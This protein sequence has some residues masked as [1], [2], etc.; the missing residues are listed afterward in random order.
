MIAKPT[1]KTI[2]LAILLI[3][4]VALLGWLFNGDHSGANPS[5]KAAKD[6]TATT[7]RARLRKSTP[8]GKRNNLRPANIDVRKR[9][10]A[11]YVQYPELAIPIKDPEKS[12]VG[13]YEDLFP[14]DDNTALH[15]ELETFETMLKKEA[16]WTEN[17]KQSAID[18]LAQEQ[19]RLNVMM[20]HSDA[21][22]HFQNSNGLS[23]FQT[24]LMPSFRLLA[25]S[26][27]LNAKLG[28]TADAIKIYQSSNQLFNLAQKG[29]LLDMTIS[30]IWRQQI[31]EY[32]TAP[33]LA[34]EAVLTGILDSPF[35]K[36]FTYS[37]TLKGEFASCTALIYGGFEL[38][39]NG[40]IILNF[41]AGAPLVSLHE[42]ENTIALYYMD[43][44]HYVQE[45][46]QSPTPPSAFDD[47]IEKLNA[48]PK[49][50]LS[51]EN[52]EIKD[53]MQVEMGVYYD[54]MQKNNFIT[55]AQQTALQI[56][57]AQSQGE[58]FTGDLPRHYKT[59]EPVIW[60]QENNILR[61]GIEAEKNQDHSTIKIPTISPPEE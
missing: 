52:Q 3:L 15:A 32:A 18:F 24:Y 26:F 25:T 12:L 40:E 27:A 36:P 1:N 42:M 44:L 46:E 23:G 11:L 20:N 17:E 14:M 31:N 37:S 50:H 61:T 39:D 21:S 51:Y 2:P 16:F 33:Q 13:L 5:K 43:L 53:L 22:Y 28:N 57:F 38:S 34:N 59:G 29:N 9:L 56:A 30:V 54:A 49:H 10:D 19:D 55:K 45:F 35:N 48:P 60:D 4:I 41:E 47:L 8:R 6:N 58:T 7:S